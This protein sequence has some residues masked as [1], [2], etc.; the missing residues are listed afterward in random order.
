MADKKKE[1]KELIEEYKKLTGK[2]FALFDEDNVK[3][4]S[5]GIKFLKNEIKAI[6]DEADDLNEGFKGIL[7]EV[8]SI[9]GELSKSNSYANLATKAFRGIRS[10][11]RDLKDDQ[12]DFN[13]L[14]L[15][16]L[17]TRKKKLASLQDEVKTQAKEISNKIQNLTLDKNGNQLIG[18]A[19]KARLKRLEIDKKITQEELAIYEGTKEGFTVFGRM[20]KEL[21]ER[22][23]KEKKIGRA[24]V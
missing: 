13:T 24:H 10:I 15:K 7:A 1:L 6:K 9:T 20:N 4:I 23:I 14:S 8:T 21:G 5:Q 2:P 17:Q 12:Q 3:D 22:I 19:L 11:T 16:E 18:A